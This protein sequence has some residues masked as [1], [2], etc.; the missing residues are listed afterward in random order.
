M[1]KVDRLIQIVRNLRE[2]GV[3]TSAIP[4]VVGTGEKSLGYN[5]NTET[6]PVFPQGKKRK[7]ATGGTGSRRL[8]LQNLRRK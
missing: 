5:I 2:E 1:N 7:Y 3:V 8:W 6:P 4:N